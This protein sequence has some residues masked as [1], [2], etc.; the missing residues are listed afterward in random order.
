MIQVTEDG[1]ESWRSVAVGSMP[2]VPATAFVNDLKADLHDA[3]TVYAALDNHK[4]GDLTPYLLQSNDRGVTWRSIR[5][6][7]PDRT[8]VWRIVQ[9][10]VK[11]ELLFT[12]PESGIYFSASAGGAWVKLTGGV[13]TISFRD[14]AIQKRENDLVGASFGR[15][16]FVLDDYSS[17]RSVSE[18]QLAEEAK[19]FPIR[20]AWW[21]H[22]R[23]VLGEVENGYIGADHFVAP[24]PDFG[25]VFTY[26][27]RDGLKTKEDI[28]Q[29][30]ESMRIETDQDIAFPGWDAVAEELA[31]SDPRIWIIVNDSD[32]N[33]VRRVSGPTNQGINR[34]AWDLRYPS[35]EALGLGSSSGSGSLGLLA[36][37]GNYS[38]T[39]VKEVD[40]EITT[41]NPPV[42]FE[43]VP[44][45]EG[46]L[47][48]SSYA[49]AAAFWR[50]YE[51]SVRT[52]S[53]VNRTL[54]N[55]LN[56]VEAMKTALSRAA[57]APGTLD[58][59]LNRLRT[60]LQDIDDRLY[61]NRAK[62]QV[63]EKR[64]PTVGSRLSAV[65]LG[66]YHSTYGPTATLRTTLQIANAQLEQIKSDLEEAQDE[67][68]VLGQDLLQAGAPWVE[69]NRLP[70]RPGG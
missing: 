33:T 55:E 30:T 7:L 38:A 6:N 68:A 15:G 35:P 39:L 29:A 65:D 1:G 24:N 51:N 4:Y 8:L 61:G 5:G 67:A 12:G 22:P 62:R 23:F 43:V 37:P 54:G 44:L 34:V 31:E 18:E 41:L 14:L 56:R 21:Y 64:S 40:G 50:A 63:G 48:G 2:G 26:H 66:V 46:A 9:D 19:L 10:H 3:N 36:A 32:G 69:G 16:F 20:K 60:K 42:R 70:R 47:Q 13:P 28:R 49:E 59:R 27:L 58:E 52:A 45:R 25:A 57:I 53:A 11:P 17:L